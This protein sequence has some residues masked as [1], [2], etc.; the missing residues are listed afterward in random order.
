MTETTHF[1]LGLHALVYLYVHGD[2]GPVRSEAIA[3]SINTNASLVRRILLSLHQAGLTSSHKGPHGGLQLARAATTITLLDVWQAFEPM[4][5][6]RQH[7]SPP[8]P[9]C[10]LGRQILPALAAIEQDLAKAWADVLGQRTIVD[11]AQN[12]LAWDRSPS[13]STQGGM[14]NA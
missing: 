12:M 11:V 13:V 7:H 1:S 9:N 3:A 5:W 14:G 10:A 8:N 6:L 4:Q 2:A